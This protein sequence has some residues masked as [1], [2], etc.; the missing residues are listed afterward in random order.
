MGNRY[1]LRKA[2]E[3]VKYFTRVRIFSKYESVDIRLQWKSGIDWVFSDKLLNCEVAYICV[4][5]NVLLICI[6]LI[7]E[8]NE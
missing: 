2:L 5:D 6:S 1:T 8:Q 3:L 4:D 7:G